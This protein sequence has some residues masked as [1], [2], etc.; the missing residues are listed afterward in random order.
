M[1]LD[2]SHRKIEGTIV[3][4]N[5]HANMAVDNNYI[6]NI[7]MKI[8]RE[9]S[10]KRVHI[11]VWSTLDGVCTHECIYLL[12]EVYNLQMELVL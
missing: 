8:C 1:L 12:H 9:P 11:H 3:I 6:V 2:V 7:L 10:K 5:M 4:Y